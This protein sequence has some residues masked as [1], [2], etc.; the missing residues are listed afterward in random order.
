MLRKSGKEKYILEVSEWIK[1]IPQI[2]TFYQ[3]DVDTLSIL[4]QISE[5]LSYFKAKFPSY[6][7]S[8][9]QEYGAFSFLTLS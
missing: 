1:K 4:L 9:L 3:L 5:I 8:F 7:C 2:I 6:V